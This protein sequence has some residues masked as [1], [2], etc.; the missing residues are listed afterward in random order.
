M[1]NKL[2]RTAVAEG[3]TTFRAGQEGLVGFVRV[4]HHAPVRTRNSV[5]LSHGGRD[6]TGRSSPDH[7]PTPTRPS[8]CVDVDD[9][10]TLHLSFEHASR[11]VLNLAEPDH[12]R[13]PPELLEIEVACEPRPRLDAHPLRSVHGIDASK[14]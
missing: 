11:D 6:Q 10:A 8:L 5:R 9:R 3:E 14:R 12:A 1:Y 4:D 7:Q 13:R 2:P